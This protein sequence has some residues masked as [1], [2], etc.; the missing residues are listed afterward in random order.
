MPLCHHLL[1]NMHPIQHFQISFFFHLHPLLTRRID[2]QNLT[3]KFIHTHKKKNLQIGYC[4][5][6]SSEVTVTGKPQ[7]KPSDKMMITLLPKGL[8]ETQ[9]FKKPQFQPRCDG[10]WS[11]YNRIVTEIAADTAVSRFL[12][13]LY[14]A[15]TASRFFNSQQLQHHYNFGSSRTYL[16][17]IFHS[18]KEGDKAAPA[19]TIQNWRHE[20]KNPLL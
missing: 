11:H 12:E 1:S 19:A 10:F 14:S 5:F 6:L 18:N 2:S 9:G 17:A 15:V 13:L 16:S 20:M 4:V 8:S 7:T 3:N